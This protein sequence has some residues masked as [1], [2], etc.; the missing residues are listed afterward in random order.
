MIYDFKCEVCEHVY[1]V[2]SAM[3]KRDEP[4]IC[5]KCQHKSHRIITS[6]ETGFI[7]KGNKWANGEARRRYG[8]NTTY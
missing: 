1:E 6:N 5:P 8:D 4:D 2:W 3:N 7:L